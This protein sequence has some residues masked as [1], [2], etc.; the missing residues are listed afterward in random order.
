MLEN[1]IQNLGNYGAQSGVS[2]MVSPSLG[3]VG[4]L[5]EGQPRRR[6]GRKPSQEPHGGLHGFV[7][8]S[9]LQRKK[10]KSFL[11]KIWSSKSKSGQ[12]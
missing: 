5:W 10:S 1:M 7:L 6:R 4:L 2:R 9:G 8:P 11:S 3:G 12:A